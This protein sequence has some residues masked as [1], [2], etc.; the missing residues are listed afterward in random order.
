MGKS[1]TS[2]IVVTGVPFIT[3]IQ[4]LSGSI[5]GGAVLSLTGTGLSLISGVNLGTSVC[6]IIEVISDTLTCV[7]TAH[8]EEVV[9][10]K[11]KESF[12]STKYATQSLNFVYSSKHSPH[13]AGVYSNT[14]DDKFR[15]VG[16]NFGKSS[17]AV[18][19]Y[20]SNLRCLVECVNETEIIC[21]LSNLIAGKYDVRVQIRK[22]G[23]S[24]IQSFIHDLVIESLSSYEGNLAN[25]IVE[26]TQF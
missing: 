15:I 4:P 24:N 16:S 9:S 12:N 18:N 20:I 1:L 6:N 3:S 2:N 19:V 5:H 21:K 22:F 7:T 11:I 14:A 25:Y 17:E 13:I 10:V 23:Y 8:N 26:K